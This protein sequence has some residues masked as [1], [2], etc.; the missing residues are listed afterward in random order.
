MCIRVLTLTLC[1]CP[2][3]DDPSLCAH[4]VNLRLSPSEISQEPFT[5]QGWATRLPTVLQGHADWK[6]SDD[7]TQ[8]EHCPAYKAR[9]RCPSDHGGNNNKVI[10]GKEHLCS[11]T[12]ELAGRSESQWTRVVRRLCEECEDGHGLGTCDFVS[13]QQHQ[14][15][16]HRKTSEISMGKPPVDVLG[17]VGVGRAASGRRASMIPTAGGRDSLSV[18]SK[19]VGVK[20]DESWI[21]ESTR[22]HASARRKGNVA[23]G[24]GSAGVSQRAGSLRRNINVGSSSG[25]RSGL[26][27]S[28]VGGQKRSPVW[29]KREWR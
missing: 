3:R 2:H 24:D 16:H 13:T 14:Q 1:I 11:E 19:T 8:W 26:T 6:L 21:R 7:Q 10:A 17:A 29:Q 23:D 25:G 28:V 20:S 12:Q 4:A 18:S 22:D 5:D 15:Q 27:R 9:N